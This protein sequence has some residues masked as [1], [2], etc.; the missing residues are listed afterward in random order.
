MTPLISKF[1]AH[2][3]LMFWPQYVPTLPFSTVAKWT[4]QPSWVGAYT[5]ANLT[6]NASGTTCIST[7][8][9]DTLVTGDAIVVFAYWDFSAGVTGSV[10]DTAG[11][12]FTGV[13]LAGKSGGSYVEMFTA[14][15]TAL[16]ST[17]LWS[18]GDDLKAGHSLNSRRSATLLIPVQE[19]VEK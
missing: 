19:G 15:V 1:L 8:H 14:P 13:S 12:V 17:D 7:G 18:L 11:N 6:C 4:N 16:N 5:V 3:L 9:F 10:S 2:L